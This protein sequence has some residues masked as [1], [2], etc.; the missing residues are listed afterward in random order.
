MQVVETVTSTTTQAIGET[1]QIARNLNPNEMS[2]KFVH[3]MTLIAI[4]LVSMYVIQDLTT[5]SGL[6]QITD[7][8]PLLAA[9]LGYFA[10]LIGKPE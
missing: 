8:F 1:F 9:T 7:L 6:I 4:V 3:Y 2:I 10:I 5:V